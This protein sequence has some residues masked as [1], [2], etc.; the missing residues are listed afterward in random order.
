MLREGA[1]P[2]THTAL[3]TATRNNQCEDDTDC[4]SISRCHV[5]TTLCGREVHVGLFT[6][7]CGSEV[8]VGLFTTL[9][10]RQVHVGLTT[11]LVG[12]KFPQ[13]LHFVGE[14]SMF[15]LL[16]VGSNS[17]RPIH[18][19]LW[20]RILVYSLLCV[21][22]NSRV[23]TALCR[24]EFR[25]FTALCRREFHIFTALCRTDLSCIH[26]SV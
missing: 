4:T 15:S 21:G 9:C 22:E 6:T 5:F 17:N 13:L 2:Y 3:H 20:E 25:V 12:E 26:C 11:T 18:Y 7:L 16:S 8:H 1:L 23:I 10:G 24:R 19:C 14:N